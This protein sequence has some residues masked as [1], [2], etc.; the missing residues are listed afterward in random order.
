MKQVGARQG[1]RPLSRQVPR[2]S[3]VRSSQSHIESD[4]QDLI[5]ECCRAAQ[6]RMVPS[7][8]FWPDEKHR[9]CVMR[10]AN[11]M[12]GY[13]Y[14]LVRADICGG[15]RPDGEQPRDWGMSIVIADPRLLRANELPVSEDVFRDPLRLD[16]DAT[17]IS[18]DRV[19]VRLAGVQARSWREGQRSVTRVPQLYR[20]MFNRMTDRSTKPKAAARSGAYRISADVFRIARPDGHNCSRLE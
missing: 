19:A 3:R 8:L 15:A 16:D 5:R 2:I 12:V 11:L 9:H 1:A 7:F 4:T 14:T 20:P 13:D 18:S 17:A 6:V 10:S